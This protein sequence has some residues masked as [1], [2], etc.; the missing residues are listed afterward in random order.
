MRTAGIPQLRRPAASAARQLRRYSGASQRWA[1]CGHSLEQST[2][3]RQSSQEHRRGCCRQGKQR[4]GLRRMGGP[5]GSRVRF[6]NTGVDA[7]AMSF[8]SSP[9]SRMACDGCHG[10]LSRLRRMAPRNTAQQPRLRCQR[11]S[12]AA[13][14]RA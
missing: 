11:C 2:R 12:P 13:W 4:T 8:S 3:Q 9:Q 1:V 6:R 7:S 10:T 5:V 14:A